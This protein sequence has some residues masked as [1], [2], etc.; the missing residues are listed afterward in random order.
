[1]SNQDQR[2]SEIF[3]MLPPASEN[4]GREKIDMAVR[5]AVAIIKEG[6]NERTGIR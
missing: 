1:M 3:N 6:K 2:L 4:G 5:K